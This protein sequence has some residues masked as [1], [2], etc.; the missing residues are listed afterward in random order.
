M[1]LTTTSSVYASSGGLRHEAVFGGGQVF[2]ASVFAMVTDAVDQLLRMF[3]P[4]ADGNSFGF[5]GDVPCCEVTI[6]VA[7]RVSGGKD[8]GAV[9]LASVTRSYPFHFV[10]L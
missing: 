5:D 2:S 6:N 7:C 8:Y 1:P 3:E 4:H 9:K 10:R